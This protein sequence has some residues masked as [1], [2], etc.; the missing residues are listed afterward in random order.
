V[1]FQFKDGSV[2]GVCKTCG[3]PAW[4][5]RSNACA[6]H[7]KS[8]AVKVKAEKVKNVGPSVNADGS[9]G[10]RTKQFVETAGEIT[11]KTFSGKAPS[12]SEWE[13]KLTALV[14][15]ATMTYV[16]YV[17]VRPFHLPEPNATEAVSIL[18]MTEDEARTIVEPCSFLLARSDINKKHGREALELLAF[19]PA[20]LAIIAWADRVSSFR[21]QM[22]AQLGDPNVS[23][24]SPQTSPGPGRTRDGVPY[25]NFG[26]VTDPGEAPTARVNGD[27][28]HLDLEDR[29]IAT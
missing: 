8:P 21:T 3:E 16:E 2:P 18:G 25:A 29:P 5:P 15:L 13:E 14:I 6:T 9:P 28:P 19:A 11:S 17:V 27:R 24:E 22:Q 10:E 4:S 1:P 26:G 12:A 20:L 23:F 7:R